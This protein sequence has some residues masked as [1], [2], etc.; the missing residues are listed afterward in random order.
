MTVYANRYAPQGKIALGVA[1]LVE[2]GGDLADYPD[3]EWLP[4]AS[5]RD[6]N[7]NVRRQLHDRTPVDADWREW[8]AGQ[9]EGSVTLTAEYDPAVRTFSGGGAGSLFALLLAKSAPTRFIISHD[10]VEVRFSGLVE[11]FGVA[12]RIAQIQVADITLRMHGAPEFP[13]GDGL[14]GV[15]ETNRGGIPI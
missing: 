10:G 2:V 13:Q 14:P 3:A 12:Y 6:V 9:A 8:E 11:S 5:L 4:V 15:S 7:V 1:L